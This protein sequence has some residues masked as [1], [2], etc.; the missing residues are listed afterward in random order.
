MQ[1]T[2]F[3][4]NIFAPIR[5]FLFAVSIAIPLISLFVFLPK[6]WALS[7]FPEVASTVNYFYFMIAFSCLFPV[8]PIFL[9]I[10]PILSKKMKLEGDLLYVYD[11]KWFNTPTMKVLHL[12]EVQKVG[13]KIL[14]QWSGKV[15]IINYWW[16]LY[17]QDGRTE[18]IYLTGWDNGTL[19]DILFN[20]KEKYPKILFD[21][22]I[23][24]D[25]SEKLTG[26]SEFL[27]K[28]KS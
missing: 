14:K 4:P 17:F 11:K 15:M 28:Q 7:K 5:L 18:E 9:T 13:E 24:R 1:N 27:K 6:V 16:V 25:S 8:F 10:Y 23:Y 12:K 26:I 20:I 21:T 19:K 3:K 2:E 22:S